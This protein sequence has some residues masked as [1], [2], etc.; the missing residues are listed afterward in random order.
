M[1]NRL[2]LALLLAL[3][4]VPVAVSAPAGAEAPEKVI[5]CHSDGNG[6]YR[7]ISISEAAYETHKTHGDP[8]PGDPVPGISYEAV[9]EY[10]CR[11]KEEPVEKSY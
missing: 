9:F 3:T 10:D 2:P 6:A 7:A 4:L 11:V 1:T 5:F 8:V